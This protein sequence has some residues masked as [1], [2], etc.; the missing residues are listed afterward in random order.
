MKKATGILFVI[1]M[2][3]SQSNI[4]G[5]ECITCVDNT[6]DFDLFA[7]AIGKDNQATGIASLAFGFKNITQGH[8]STTIG[9][10]LQIN[11]NVNSAIIIGSGNSDT[12][13]LISNI[14]N[15]FMVGF[16]SN[17]PTFFVG[18]SNG[19]STTGR[20]G[21]G[22][23]SPLAKL[24]IYSNEDESATLFLQQ[25]NWTSDLFAQIWLG[26]MDHGISAELGAGMVYTTEQYHV[27]KGGDVFIEDIDKGIIMKSPDGNCWRGVL[28]NDGN[29]HFTALETCPEI[30]VAVPENNEIKSGNNLKVYPNPTNDYLTVELTIANQNQHAVS[31]LDEKGAVLITKRFQ[32]SQTKLYTGDLPAGI[33]FV[34]LTGEKAELVQKVIKQ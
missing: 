27:F 15:S 32:S 6:V 29:L 13:K 28:D 3:I 25:S 9:K 21:I 10:Y 1:L 16:N 24:H 2:I 30:T 14:G 4:L 17:L 5:Q 8:Y 11:T 23:S 22:T 19:Q 34:H 33:Y 31:L 20:I 12:D 18:G 26:D 7:S